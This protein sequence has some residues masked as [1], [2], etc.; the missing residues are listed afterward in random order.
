VAA[1]AFAARRATGTC[2]SWTGLVTPRTRNALRLLTSEAISTLAGRKERPV[3]GRCAR[4]HS[5]GRSIGLGKEGLRYADFR[6]DTGPVLLVSDQGGGKTST[7][8]IW[9]ILRLF[10]VKYTDRRH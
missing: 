8:I 7:L 4:A 9:F 2:E 10:L 3:P 6:A 1:G 5:A